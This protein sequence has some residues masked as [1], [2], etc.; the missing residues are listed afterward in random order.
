MPDRSLVPRQRQAGDTVSEELLIHGATTAKGAKGQGRVIFGE[1]QRLLGEEGF[2]SLAYDTRGVGESE[3]EFHNSTLT[4]RLADAENAYKFFTCNQ[5]VDAGRIAVFGLSMGGHIA[6]RLVGL[7]PEKFKE[8]VLVNAAAYGLQ[9]EDKRLKPYSE[10]TDAIRQNYS[11]Q[12][13][14][15]FVD[16]LKFRGAVMTADSEFD[17]VV[18]QEVKDRYRLSIVQLDRHLVLP[19]V[20]HAFFF[21]I[22]QQPIEARNLLYKEMI[23]SFKQNL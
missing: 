5:F 8:V 21:T 11:W 17:D 14:L 16:L 19:S 13:S 4:H 1:F 6:A 9:A 20:K 23:D 2:T 12:N 18:P 10:F 22:D 3:G 7:H 15:V